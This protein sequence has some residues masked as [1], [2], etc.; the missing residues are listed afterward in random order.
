MQ[1]QTN[2]ETKIAHGKPYTF[3]PLTGCLD[4]HSLA[5][6]SATIEPLLEDHHA[7]LVFDLGALDLVNSH[8]VGYFENIYRKLATTKKRMAFVNANTEIREILEL[9]GLSKL[10][11]MFDEEDKF[12][13]AIR[14]GEI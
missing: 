7:Y 2:H 11:A 4:E 1:T 12:V 9:V 10:A 3:V 8:A 14:N 5:E 6:F 13:E